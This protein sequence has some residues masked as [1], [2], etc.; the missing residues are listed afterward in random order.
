MCA[1]TRRVNCACQLCTWRVKCACDLCVVWVCRFRKYPYVILRVCTVR[2]YP[3]VLQRKVRIPVSSHSFGSS[4]GNKTYQPMRSNC[5]FLN[6]TL[7]SGFVKIS[8]SWSFVSIGKTEIVLSATCFLKWWY[9]IAICFVLGVNFEHSATLTQLLLSSNNLQWNSGLGLWRGRTSPTSTI[10]FMKGITYLIAWD[11][12]M[13]SDSVVLNA[14]SVCSLLHYVRGHPSY[15]IIKP[16]LYR[17]HSG[18]VWSPDD[19]PPA[20][21]APT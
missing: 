13:Y 18:L 15:I 19:Q 7:S 14:I 12:A 20:K 8:A 16:V 17:T 21:S 11:R 4:A 6:M 10:K 1:E 2:K 5:S 9:L 3:Y